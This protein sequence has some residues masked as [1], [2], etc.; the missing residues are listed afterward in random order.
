MATRYW[1]GDA[2][3]V[4]EITTLTFSG[5][6]ATNDTATVTI[7]GKSGTVTIGSTATLA[8]VTTAVKRMI[9]GTALSDDESRDVGGLTTYSGEFGASYSVEED[10][11]NYVITITGTPGEPLTVSSSESTA[12]S[13]AIADST[14]QSPTGKNWADNAANWVGGT[15][16]TTDDTVIFENGSQ[17]CK[18]GLSQL[19]DMAQI[20]FRSTW[21][22][23]FGLPPYNTSVSGKTFYQSETQSLALTRASG[24]DVIIGE[25]GATGGSTMIR[26]DLNG[27]SNS[28]LTVHSSGTAAF[29]SSQGIAA[30]HIDGCADITANITGGDVW[31]ETSSTTVNVGGNSPTV[32]VSGT[33]TLINVDG[34]TGYSDGNATAITQDGGTW[35]HEDGTCGTLTV[36]AG[37]HN[38]KSTGT[39]TSP[40]VGNAGTLSMD[41]GVGGVTFTNPL[42]VYGTGATFTDSKRRTGAIVVDLNGATLSQCNLGSHLRITAGTVA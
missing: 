30:V 38:Y 9:D 11:S 17:S 27:N 40:A 16:P 35:T 14:V 19:A 20:E 23:Q 26:L 15:A 31:L 1:R 42:E 28:S 6:W 24:T 4:P 12:G 8:E 13:G 25:E 34:G 32:R 22:G 3:D 10:L 7:N 18:Y 33:T 36:M 29:K 5:T 39:V 21:T 41:A 2:F 37:T